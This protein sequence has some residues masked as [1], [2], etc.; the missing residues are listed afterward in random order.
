MLCLRRTVCQ[1]H[2][3][4]YEWQ[5]SVWAD[6]GADPEGDS[7]ITAAGRDEAEHHTFISE[8]GEPQFDDR[9]LD[10]KNGLGI[11]TFQEKSASFSIWTESYFEESFLKPQELIF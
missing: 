11:F 6:Y 2:S 10:Y 1:P 7:H 3:G 5:E 9:F 8:A 4:E